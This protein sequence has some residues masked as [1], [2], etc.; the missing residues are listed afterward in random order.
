[1]CFVQKK[2]NKQKQCELIKRHY[3]KKNGNNKAFKL[4]LSVPKAKRLF[5][6]VKIAF[7][8]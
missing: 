3:K 8:N 5:K 1:M 6:A 4:Y 2:W 7:V